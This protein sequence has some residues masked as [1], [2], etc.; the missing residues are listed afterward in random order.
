MKQL[1]IATGLLTAGALI[2]VIGPNA[3]WWLLGSLR[4]EPFYQ[5]QPSSYWSALISDCK[6][7]PFLVRRS[8]PHGARQ[9]APPMV[10]FRC[11][12]AFDKA[13]D[14]LTARIG[15]PGFSGAEQR[16][17]KSADVEALPVLIT[18]LNDPSAQV[19]YYAVQQIEDF[20]DDGLVALPA[21][22]KLTFDR[23]VAFPD[24]RAMYPHQKLDWFD[25]HA[26]VSDAAY[27]PIRRLSRLETPA[28]SAWHLDY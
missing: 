5:G 1:A 7:S 3:R 4:G 24:T 11:A 23:D 16:P 8:G 18:L 17:F 26:T 25:W 12:S 6:A 13:R 21:L 22:R 10:L 20:G 14:W 28:R 2:V 15:W 27:W 19:R 9:H